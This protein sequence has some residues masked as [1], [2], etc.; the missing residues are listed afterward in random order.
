MNNLENSIKDC[1]TKEIEK[2]IIEKVIA[3]QLEKCIEKSISDMFGWNG[4]IKKVI[5]NKVKSVM[6]PYLE[7]YDYSEYITK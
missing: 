1:I 4:E 7:D 3:E 6:I 2:G 5:E